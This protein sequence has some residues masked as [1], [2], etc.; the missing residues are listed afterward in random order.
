M[1]LRARMVRREG[2][3]FALMRCG[4][5][6]VPEGPDPRAPTGFRRQAG[7]PTTIRDVV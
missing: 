4:F 1:A 2:P 5:R 6:A 3:A 7:P